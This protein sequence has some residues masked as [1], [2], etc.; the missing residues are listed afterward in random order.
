M[1]WP[2]PAAQATTFRRGTGGTRR[3]G[4]AGILY[5]LA[6]SLVLA[7]CGFHLRGDVTYAFASVYINFPATA[8]ITRELRRAL[9]GGGTTVADTAA[10]AP[11]ALDISGVADDKQVLSL[12]GGGRVREFQLTKRVTFA[13]RDAA[14]RDWLPSA[15]IVI[16]RSFSF[17]ESEV[18]AR[19]AEEA[20]L[21]REMQTDAVQQI[22][23]RLQT[24]QKPS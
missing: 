10:A 12:T 19:E 6:V 20:R 9:E 14:G 16:L 11:V 15:E 22:L 4:I 1:S 8:P 21:L 17:N 13:L 3:P 18:L 7:G 5:A 24:A 23:R 2:D